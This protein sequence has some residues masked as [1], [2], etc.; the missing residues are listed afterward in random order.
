MKCVDCVNRY[1]YKDSDFG[2]VQPC[3]G[4]NDFSFFK[5]CQKRNFY[6]GTVS[7]N[8]W[9]LMKCEVKVL[10]KNKFRFELDLIGY[11]ERDMSLKGACENGRLYFDHLAGHTGYLNSEGTKRFV[12]LDP[13][14][15][16]INYNI[17]KFMEV[18]SNEIAKDENPSSREI[19]ETIM[20]C[21][22]CDWDKNL[23]LHIN[24]VVYEH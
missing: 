18:V 11:H 1:T 17:G 4:C 12:K 9:N 24:E 5:S 19:C 21:G 16:Y 8:P 6:M 15:I 2:E 20:D 13:D 7:K 14:D 22:S 10:T 23:K 3:D